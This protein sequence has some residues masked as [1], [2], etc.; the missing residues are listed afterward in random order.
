MLDLFFC[1]P[2]QFCFDDKDQFQNKHHSCTS[3]ICMKL[4]L[5]KIENRKLEHQLINE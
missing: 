4:I 2:A 3:F 5:H 1:C